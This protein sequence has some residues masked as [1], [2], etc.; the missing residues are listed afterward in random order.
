MVE[1]LQEAFPRTPR[2]AFHTSS[3]TSLVHLYSLLHFS[4]LDSLRYAFSA[5]FWHPSWP[6]SMSV[7]W[8]LRPIFFAERHYE[9]VHDGTFGLYLASN[10]GRRE[11]DHCDTLHHG[12]P[13][14]ERTEMKGESRLGREGQQSERTSVSSDTHSAKRER[15]K[16]EAA[17]ERRVSVS[18]PSGLECRAA[19]P[20]LCASAPGLKSISLALPPSLFHAVPAALQV[21]VHSTTVSRIPAAL[22]WQSSLSCMRVPSWP[23]CTTM[24]RLADTGVVF[25]N[26]GPAIGKIHIHSFPIVSSRVSFSARPI[27]DIP[28]SRVPSV[29]AAAE[30]LYSFSSRR[31]FWHCVSARYCCEERNF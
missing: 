10:I 7:A 13:N 16:A 18:S 27:S 25:L 6:P 8:C 29:A 15:A 5:F 22:V 24:Q 1:Q 21:R 4:R 14:R 3:S 26:V 30:F 20:V 12:R 31:R 28:A 19:L 9:F 2:R 17:R 23:W 11:R